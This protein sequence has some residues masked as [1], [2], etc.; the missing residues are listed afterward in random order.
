MIKRVALAADHGGYALKNHIL[1]FLQKQGY[2]CTDCGVNSAESVDYPDYAKAA[3]E[4]VQKGECECALLFCT[5]GVGM[6][7]AANKMKG[8]RACCCSD[9]LSAE[10]TRKHNGANVLCMGQNI[11]GAGLAERLAEAFLTAELD[12]ENPR[13]ARRIGKITGL[14]NS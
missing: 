10:M 11:V 1:A 12:E 8:I 13:H 6:S 7:I 2:V 3:C 5:T 4:M 14:E 9:T